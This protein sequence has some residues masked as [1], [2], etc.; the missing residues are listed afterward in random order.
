MRVLRTTGMVVLAGLLMGALRS[1]IDGRDA[2]IAGV[3]VEI[4]TR[5]YPAMDS[6]TCDAEIRRVLNIV[7]HDVPSDGW[8]D[9]HLLYRLRADKCIDKNFWVRVQKPFTQ[10]SIE[11]CKRPAV[12][13]DRVAS[14][15]RVRISQL[16]SVDDFDDALESQ[17][18]YECSI[19][20]R[21]L[22]VFAESVR[23][24]DI[25]IRFGDPYILDLQ[26]NPGGHVEYV[27]GA[28]F[29]PRAFVRAYTRVYRI[30][31]NEFREEPSNRYPGVLGCP[32]VILVDEHTASGAEIVTETLRLWCLHAVVIGRHTF[33]K[34]AG[35]AK[36]PL[37][38]F[39]ISVPEDVYLFGNDEHTV[40]IIGIEPDIH[41]PKGDE[42]SHFKAALEYVLCNAPSAFR[43]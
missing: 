23:W 11:R 4:T 38:D 39:L 19:P 34:G 41:L 13:L 3:Y 8:N 30:G 22:A 36:L 33:G 43:R 7:S 6:G 2:A 12:S 14:V 29:A 24:G 26:G 37:G 15:W 16:G 28:L 18:E 9:E 27:L 1:D 20:F 10:R 21:D 5:M 32:Q 25:P 42:D 31:P 35:T 17:R 40:N